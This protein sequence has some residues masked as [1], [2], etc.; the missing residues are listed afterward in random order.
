MVVV[1]H[2]FLSYQIAC[3]DRLNDSLRT[4]VAELDKKIIEID[5][6]QKEKE[7][8]LAR[9]GIIQQ[10]QSDRQKIVRLFDNV[11]RTVPEGLYLTTLNRTG[12]QLLIEGKAESNTRVSKFMRNIEAS[13]WLS[14][15][16]LNLIQAD[17][18]GKENHGLGFTLQAVQ[19]PDKE[20]KAN[21]A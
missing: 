4:E 12:V 18:K 5:N 3:Q 17:E 6:L 14:N 20:E 13:A 11:T 10:L 16:V 15:P 7:N 21:K 1:L 8:L 2:F 19:A 9:M